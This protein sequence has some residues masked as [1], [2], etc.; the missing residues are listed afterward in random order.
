MGFDVAGLSVWYGSKPIL[1]DVGFNL[2][3]GSVCAIL[4]NNGAGK[5]TLLKALMGVI[6]SKIG[7]ICLDGVGLPMGYPSG[8]TKWFAYVPQSPKACGLTVFEAILLGRRPHINDRPSHKDFKVVDD[9]ISLMGLESLAFNTLDRISGGELQKVTI[10]RALAQ[11]PRV[12]LLDEPISNLDIRNQMEVEGLLQRLAKSHGL[13][14]I[15]VLHDLNMAMRFSDIFMFIK[16]GKIHSIGGV[17]TITPDVLED[18]Y[19]VRMQILQVNHI[20]VV[21]PE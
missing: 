17:D 20:P 16:A 13:I 10:G 21:V 12:L 3:S 14:V 8:R 19:G 15:Q 2:V 6:P 7:K 4:G 1:V 9:V 5:T 18:I 11:E